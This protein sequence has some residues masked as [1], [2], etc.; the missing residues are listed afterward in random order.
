M[1]YKP[2]I[3]KP[4][5]LAVTCWCERTV[6]HVDRALVLAGQTASCGTRRCVPELVAA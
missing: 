2:L 1:T 3:V 5:Q 6:V 4:G